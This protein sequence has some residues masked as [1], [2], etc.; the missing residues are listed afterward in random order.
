MKCNYDTSVPVAGVR[1]DTIVAAIEDRARTETQFCRLLATPDQAFHPVQ[2]RILVLS[3]IGHVDAIRR[4]V[5]FGK[6]PDDV[7]DCSVGETALGAGLPLHGR[8][9]CQAAFDVEVFAHAD[10]L[11]VEEHGRTRQG[12]H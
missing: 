5:P 9:D 1:E 7:L 10:F 8:T 4:E 12:E 11:T 2:Q 3:L 6:G